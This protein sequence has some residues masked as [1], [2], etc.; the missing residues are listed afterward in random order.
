M[1]SVKKDFETEKQ[2]FSEHIQKAVCG[3]R[4]REI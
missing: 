3:T 1:T 2:V 4:R